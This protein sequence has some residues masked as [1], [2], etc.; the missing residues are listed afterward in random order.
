MAFLRLLRLYLAR[1]RTLA[2]ALR[3]AWAK[4]RTPDLPVSPTLRKKA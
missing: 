2:N 3:Q 4:A 1:G